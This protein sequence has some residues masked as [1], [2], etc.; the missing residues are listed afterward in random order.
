MYIQYDTLDT[1]RLILENISGDDAA[2]YYSQFGSGN[3]FV[4]KY[5][6][7]MEPLSSVDDARQAI[8][9]YTAFEPKLQ[10]CWI[11]KLR[12][13]GREIGTCGLHYRN[14]ENNS[15][16]IGYSLDQEYTG[17]GYMDES[18]KEV[19]KY[20]T[21]K[22]GIVKISACIFVENDRSKNLIEKNGFIKNG[23]K[24]EVFRGTEYLHDIYVLERPEPIGGCP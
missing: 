20:C 18:I 4:N 24:V 8:D 3:D 10:H 15:C 22:L 9:W 21:A 16:E 2:F 1:D 12:E 13:S 14:I 5:L 6:F 17:M 19:I 23:S 7:D 11:I